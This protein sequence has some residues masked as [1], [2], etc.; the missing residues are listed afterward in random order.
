MELNF[1][2]AICRVDVPE[3]AKFLARYALIPSLNC[4][5]LQ[6]L[7]VR[8]DDFARPNRLILFQIT[9][10]EDGLVDEYFLPARRIRRSL[11]LLLFS[12]NGII[13]RLLR[14]HKAH[15]IVY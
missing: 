7:L 12:I 14:L 8:A 13:R 15:I 1:V 3:L 11:L 10:L 2:S 4:L 6:S 5:R 9:V